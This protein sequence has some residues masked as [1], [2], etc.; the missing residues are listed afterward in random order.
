[1][2]NVISAADTLL[3]KDK[4]MAGGILLGATI[5]YF[6]LEHSGFTLMTIFSNL[7]LVAFA[8]MF[9][10]SNAAVFLNRLVSVKIVGSFVYILFLQQGGLS[11][12]LNYLRFQVSS[13]FARPS[14]V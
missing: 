4:F 3:W 2:W 14:R 12:N 9:V 7:L 6:V 5:V 10:W 13:P 1:M 11:S 8:V